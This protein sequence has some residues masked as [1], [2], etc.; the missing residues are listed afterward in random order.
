MHSN[1]I[2]PRKADLIH[3]V[4][5][6]TTGHFSWTKPIQALGQMKFIQ[7]ITLLQF[8]QNNRPY[9]T[10]F[11]LV[12][13]ST[14][15]IMNTI[16]NRSS[17]VVSTSSS[18]ADVIFYIILAPDLGCLLW[19]KALFKRKLPGIFAFRSPNIRKLKN[20]SKPDRT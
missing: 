16:L 11:S 14:I 1:E 2:F 5:K 17:L 12:P 6:P 20:G 3:P 13:L 7:V 9:F 10:L 15:I 18:S 4:A 8:Y 19:L